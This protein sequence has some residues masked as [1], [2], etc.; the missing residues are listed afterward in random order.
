MTQ[1]FREDVISCRAKEFTERIYKCFF[2]GQ[3]DFSLCQAH[4]SLHERMYILTRKIFDAWTWTLDTP[5]RA[6][7]FAF[8]ANGRTEDERSLVFLN[9]G[10]NMRWFAEAVRC[11]IDIP[12]VVSCTINFAYVVGCSVGWPAP[13]AAGVICYERKCAPDSMLVWWSLCW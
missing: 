2:P 8:P 5:K 9:T 12:I 7:N 10:S 3:N 4:V 13:C 6:H 1:F 11:F